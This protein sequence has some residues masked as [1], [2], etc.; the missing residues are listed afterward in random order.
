[1]PAGEP[2]DDPTARD[3]TTLVKPALRLIVCEVAQRGKF[4]VGEPFFEGSSQLPLGRRGSLQAAPGDLVAVRPERGRAVVVERLGTPADLAAVLRGLL[5]ERGV[6]QPFPE[7]VLAETQRV[8]GEPAG[9]DPG[10]VDL[11]HL[12]CVTIDPPGARDFDDAVTVLAEGDA[13][14]VYVHIADVAFHVRPDGP[15]DREAERRATSVYVPGAVEPMLP[16]ALSSGSCSLL[17]GH[18]RRVLTVEVVVGA[19]GEVGEPRFHRALIESRARL[20][21]DEAHAILADGVDHPQA[22]LLRRADLVAGR[23]RVRRMRRGAL[24]IDPRELVIEVADG[25]VRSATWEGEARAHALVEELM[26]LANEAV[27]R[28]LAARKAPSLYRVHEQ[29]DPEAIARLL[30][31]LGALGVP[32]VPLPD[33][34]AG[35]EPSELIARQA[36]LVRA[37]VK[38]RGSGNEAFTSQLLRTLKLARYDARNLGHAGLASGAYCHFTSPIRRYP[39]LVVHRALCAGL[40]LGELPPQRDELEAL[41]EHCSFA[42][43]EAADAERRADAICLATLL[44]ARLDDGG[45]EEVSEG[46]ITGVISAGIFARFDEVFEGFLPVRKLDRA[47]RYDLDEQGVALVGRSSS[48]SFRI[49]DPIRVVVDSVDRPRGRV[50]LD[51]VHDGRRGR[52]DDRDEPPRPSRVPHPRPGRGRPRSHRH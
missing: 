38:R 15:I 49:G 23:L 6:A 40:G 39:D 51:W 14:R 33:R 42:E 5:I 10:R 4:L 26:L 50:E 27:A 52:E 29:P 21:Y 30:A 18:P 47:D 8:A 16:H 35:T 22:E 20:T 3:T 34:L 31:R 37:E 32:L 17:A 43:R 44:R 48:R 46:E 1:M 7:D 45:W 2:P 25:G 12:P 24:A 13:S 11:R 9:L 36:Q 28:Y 19:D 41:A